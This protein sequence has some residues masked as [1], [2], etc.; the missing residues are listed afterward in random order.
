M[1]A[2]IL[3]AGNA[4]SA[5]WITIDDIRINLPDAY[6]KPRVIKKKASRKL[7]VPRIMEKDGSEP[8][9][10]INEIDTGAV[11]FEKRNKIPETP[12]D[13]IV[14]FMGTIPNRY[15]DFKYSEV[16][17]IKIDGRL[18]ARVTWTG[19]ISHSKFG[20]FELRGMF[21]ACRAGN[22]IYQINY[23][24][25]AKTFYKYLPEAVKAFK[26]IRFLR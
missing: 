9:I 5:K 23:S 10:F 16:K 20:E 7:V 2:F 25:H 11:S 26:E 22:K 6:E 3:T 18:F 19:K 21:M 1:T 15:S 8:V 14:D 24:D 13:N 12:F 4:L 17:K